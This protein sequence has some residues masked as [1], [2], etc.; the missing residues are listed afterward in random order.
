MGT[1]L[2]SLLFAVSALAQDFAMDNESGNAVPNFVGQLTVIK[3]KVFK[4]S[5]GQT[6]EAKVGMRFYKNDAIKT[7]DQ[8]LAK[9]TIVDDTI[10]SIAPNS[11]LNFSEFKFVTKEDREII[12]SLIKGQI[13]AYVKKKAT[14]DGA[15]KVR[16]AY[17]T[18]GVRGTEILANYR[19]IKNVGVSEFALLSGKASVTDGDQKTFDLEMNER[20]ILVEDSEMNKRANEKSKLS[21]PLA[22][23]LNATLVDEGKEFKP[24]LPFSLI[25]D[26]ATSSEVHKLLTSEAKADSVHLQDSRGAKMPTG[27]GSLHNLEKLNEK[28][29]KNKQ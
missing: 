21:E 1:L 8:S 13:A 18:L 26:L 17:T 9:L 27:K 15:I 24:F 3:G 2:L 6:S 11:E 7:G 29:R 20:L 28:L 23:E 22:K 25:S 12:Y 5:K 16:T 14:K 10:L 4:V 19:K